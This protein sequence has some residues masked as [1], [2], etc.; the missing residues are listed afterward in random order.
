MK[1]DLLPRVKK[2]FKTNL[3]T[4][5]NISDGVLTPEE[6]VEKYKSAGYQVLS[7]TDHNVIVDHSD[8]NT[9]DFLLLTGVEVNVNDEHFKPTK[10]F[11]GQTYHLNLIAKRPD[12]LWQPVNVVRIRETAAPYEDLVTCENMPRVYDV[13]NINNM[14]AKSNEM[15]FL[16]MY[17]H[18]VWS[19]QRGADY[20]PL[21]GLWAMELRNN[22]SIVEGYN[23]NNHGVYQEMLESGMRLFPTGTDDA[24]SEKGMFGAW[25]MVGAE[26]LAYGAVIKALEKGDFYMSCGPEIHSLTLE[27]GILEIECS[28]AKEIFV[29]THA[30][31]S[32]CAAAE[33]GKSL[34]RASF[35]LTRFFGWNKLVPQE[36]AF[37][38]VTVFGHDGSYAATRAYWA[39][40]F[41]LAD[42]GD[43]DVMERYR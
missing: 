18:P 36:Q 5:S 30:R 29:E 43:V 14:I 32:R 15:G 23:E 38:R 17:N 33:A 26:E 7:I 19:G 8:K 10:G 9:E 3:H 22:A 34:N 16:V 6:V 21:K 24:H 1:R 31:I 40:E 13:E 41:T 42:T 37:F 11:W 25:I 27:N 35:D 2:Y 12:N 28:D 20:L 39:E 4:H